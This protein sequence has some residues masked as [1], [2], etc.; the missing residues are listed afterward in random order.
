MQEIIKKLTKKTQ[1]QLSSLNNSEGLV[2]DGH[3]ETDIVELQKM[4]DRESFFQETKLTE[5]FNERLP[6]QR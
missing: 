1:L 4:L 2:P 3:V 6:V 5:S